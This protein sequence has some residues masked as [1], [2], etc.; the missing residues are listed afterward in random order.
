MQLQKAQKYS[1]VVSLFTL[2]GSGRA[3][4]AR[5]MLV[6]LT[7]YS[8]YVRGAQKHKRGSEVVNSFTLLGTTH[9]KAVRKNV[10]E[11]DHR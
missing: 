5:R 3:K 11:I 2:L 1:Q 8:F 6:K 10:D 9:V 7:P 4:A